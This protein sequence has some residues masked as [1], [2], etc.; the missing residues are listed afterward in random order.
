MRL[1]RGTHLPPNPA[2]PHD[3]CPVARAVE[4]RA[5]EFDRAV[6]ALGFLA[7]AAHTDDGG[8]PR[9]GQ[10]TPAMEHPA[11]FAACLAVVADALTEV[12][13]VIRP[14]EYGEPSEDTEPP[15]GA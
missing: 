7:A 14:S 4:H 10:T 2:M 5:Y 1:P 12:H 11:G 8:T 13:A 6:Y 3:C 15:V 9:A